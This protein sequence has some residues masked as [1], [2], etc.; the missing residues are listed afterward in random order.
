MATFRRSLS[1][2]EAFVLSLAII[3]PTLAMAFNV[4][5]AVQA[6][7]RAAPLAFLIGG[8][9]MALIGLSFVAFSR[10]IA[11]A[12]SAYAYVGAV[13]GRR[14]G[15]LAGWGL[16]LAYLAF[17]ASATGLV[18]GFLGVALEHLG[19]ALPGL[20]QA[21][22]AG[23]GLLVIRLGGRE[24][25][26][27]AVIM[28]VIEAA[29]VLAIVV[30]AATILARVPL[31][32]A[33]FVPDA[34]HGWSG[35]GFAMVFAVLSLAGFEGAATLAEETRDPH[36][37]IPLAIIGSLVV[38]TLLYTLVSYAQVLGYGPEGVAELGAA[39]APLGAL[40]ARYV[41]PG[42]G[43]FLDLA[44][45]ISSLAC[46]LGTAAAA[47]RILCALGRGGLSARLA[48]ID[49]EHGAPRRATRLIGAGNIAALLVFG[50][51]S[52]SRAYS[53]GF[54]TVATLVLILVYMGVGLAQMVHAARAGRR[55]MSAVGLLGAALLAWP[56]LNS[57]YPVPGWPGFLWPLAVLAWMAGGALIALARPG[58]AGVPERA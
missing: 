26:S 40:A 41:S 48:E 4:P 30:L 47:A 6:G 14:S 25:R 20:W 46:A 43:V 28:L 33:P 53:E 8:A 5:L 49:P 50:G 52:G 34:A 11:T 2:F 3:A 58:R 54:A 42:Y 17:L 56:F 12:G 44:A 7:G 51:L 57:L 32:A 27:I 9:A 13:F 22:A 29:A 10:R 1:A 36:R 19:I 18:G 38:A 37:S 16:L 31:T 21:I 55:L 39:H 15:F 23:A 35:L 45:G 24:I